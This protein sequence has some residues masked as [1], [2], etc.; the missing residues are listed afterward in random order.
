M[1]APIIS[2][3]SCKGGVGKSLT[4]SN[5]AIT[6]SDLG[7]KVLVVDM[8]PQSSLSKL[9]EWANVDEN[10]KHKYTI[11]DLLLLVSNL[12]KNNNFTDVT[13]ENLSNVIKS[14]IFKSK[15]DIDLLPSS[16]LWISQ[17]DEIDSF[18]LPLHTK[19][20]L[21]KDILN[22]IRDDYDLI[23]IDTTPTTVSIPLQIALSAS[24]YGVV[25]SRPDKYFLDSNNGSFEIARQVIQSANPQLKLLGVLVNVFFKNRKADRLF[26]DLIRKNALDNN[27]DVFKVVIPERAV[28]NDIYK[29]SLIT[30]SIKNKKTSEIRELFLGIANEIELKTGVKNDKQ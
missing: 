6:F 9:F 18:D 3:Y 29:D 30:C 26:L 4:C 2:V 20:K 19:L 14:I 16:R 17:I 27:V 1:K 12:H 23:L 7:Y 28:I 8:D 15:Y 10:F 11:G 25:I 24:N 22:L 13:K 5:L 21:L